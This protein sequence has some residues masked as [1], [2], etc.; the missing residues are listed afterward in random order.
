MNIP[1]IRGPI[2]LAE[3]T[4]MGI[5]AL[6]YST[7]IAIEDETPKTKKAGTMSNISIAATLLISLAF[8]LFLFKFIPLYATQFA[9]NHWSFFAQQYTFNMTEGI[10]KIG[11]LVGYIY[12]I[13]LFPDIQRVFQYHGAEHKV[14][15][16]WENKDLYNAKKYSTTHVRCGT[17]FILFVMALS[18]LVYILVPI[19]M[20][21]WAKYGLR[22]AL[23]PVIMG[24]SYEL[25]KIS[26]KYEKQ[27]WF[28]ILISPGL[29]MQRLTTR[30]PNDRQLEVATAAL[31]A[32]I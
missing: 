25:I 29:L 17:S 5:K 22:I 3:T 2:I 6:N 32:A 4:V 28:K 27:A 26:P 8:A 18:I 19:T 9:A 21:F 14:V 1:F 12:S 31:L 24:I 20:G 10:L 16:A 13:S 23:L 30:Q 15:N 7:D 11:L